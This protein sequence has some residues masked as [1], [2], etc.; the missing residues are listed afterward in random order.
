M[1]SCWVN[2][3]MIMIVDMNHKRMNEHGG[4]DEC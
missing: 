2:V 4:D 1:H 3:L